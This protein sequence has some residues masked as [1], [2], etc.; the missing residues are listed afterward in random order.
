M[1]D[2]SRYLDWQTLGRLPDPHGELV[3]S[4]MVYQKH[5]SLSNLCG[6]PVELETM[7]LPDRQLLIKSHIERTC[8]LFILLTDTFN[9][10]CLNVSQFSVSND[11]KVAASTS[12]I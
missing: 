10:T 5:R 4:L 8:I 12:R 7:E 9:D 1:S 6:P 3:V 11:K 2:V